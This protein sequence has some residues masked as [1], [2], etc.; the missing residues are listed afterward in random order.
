MSINA[1]NYSDNS[2]NSALNFTNSNTANSLQAS[3][4]QSTGANNIV[5]H[6]KGKKKGEPDDLEAQLQVLLSNLSQASSSTAP[7]ANINA[8]LKNPIVYQLLV[9]LG[10]VS[11]FSLATH[12]LLSVLPEVTQSKEAKLDSTKKLINDIINVNRE[13]SDKDIEQLIGSAMERLKPNYSIKNDP[14]KK[15]ILSFLLQLVY[16]PEQREKLISNYDKLQRF[17]DVAF[18]TLLKYIFLKDNDGTDEFKSLA[19]SSNANLWSSELSLLCKQLDAHSANKNKAIVECLTELAGQFELTTEERNIVFPKILSNL[20]GQLQKVLKKY[21]KPSDWNRDIKKSSII[22]QLSLIRLDELFNGGIYDINYELEGN[23][24]RREKIGKIVQDW[25]YKSYS[26]QRTTE[27]ALQDAKKQKDSRYEYVIENTLKPLKAFN[28]LTAREGVHSN[29]VLKIYPLDNKL[30]KEHLSVLEVL[31]SS[32]DSAGLVGVRDSEFF[33]KNYGVYGVGGNVKYETNA[34]GVGLYSTT[35]ALIDASEKLEKILYHGNNQFTNLMIDGKQIKTLESKGP[36]KYIFSLFRS[37]IKET[38]SYGDGSWEAGLSLPEQFAESLGY[39][40][41]DSIRDA[42]DYLATKAVEQVGKRASKKVLDEKIIELGKSDGFKQCLKDIKQRLLSRV[43]PFDI[44]KDVYEEKSQKLLFIKPPQ[45]NNSLIPIPKQDYEYLKNSSFDNLDN[46]LS[47][48]SNLYETA[49]ISVVVHAP[50]PDHDKHFNESSEYFFMADGLHETL[51][52]W[53]KAAENIPEIKNLLTQGGY[54]CL[55][56][57][58]EGF[59]DDLKVNVGKKGLFSMTYNGLLKYNLKKG[60]GPQNTVTYFELILGKLAKHL[61][62]HPEPLA[63]RQ[64]IMHGDSASDIVAVLKSLVYA[65]DSYGVQVRAITTMANI[66]ELTNKIFCVNTIKSGQEE[67]LAD[68]QNHLERICWKNERNEEFYENNISIQDIQKHLSTKF[69]FEIGSGGK[70][71]VLNKD[72]VNHINKTKR[73]DEKK[74]ILASEFLQGKVFDSEKEFNQYLNRISKNLKELREHFVNPY[75]SCPIL[76]EIQKD[77]KVKIVGAGILNGKVFDTE[78]AYKDFIFAKDSWFDKLFKNRLIRAD[79]VDHQIR[80]NALT[81]AITGGVPIETLEELIDNPSLLLDKTAPHRREYIYGPHASYV[82][83][84]EAF[85]KNLSTPKEDLYTLKNSIKEKLPIFTHRLVAGS[86]ISGMT[87]AAILAASFIYKQLTKDEYTP[88]HSPSIMGE[89]KS[90][91]R[92]RKHSKYRHTQNDLKLLLADLNNVLSTDPKKD[93]KDHKNKLNK[94]IATIQNISANMVTGGYIGMN[95]GSLLRNLFLSYPTQSTG[96]LGNLAALS[97]MFI[98]PQNI[99]LQRA[100]ILGSIALNMLSWANSLFFSEQLNVRL[101]LDP[102]KTLDGLQSEFEFKT[103]NAEHNQV[104]GK[105]YFAASKIQQI[106]KAGLDLEIKLL[107][108]VF[109][110]FFVKFLGGRPAGFVANFIA[111]LYKPSKAVWETAKN[112]KFFHDMVLYGPEVQEITRGQIIN[113]KM[114]S[115]KPLHEKIIN[116]ILKPFPMP[117]GV[118]FIISWGAFV[119]IAGL[120]LGSILEFFKNKKNDKDKDKNSTQSSQTQNDIMNHPAS[121]PL[122]VATT[123]SA[124]IPGLANATFAPIERIAG[125]G[126]PLTSYI[127]G[128]NSQ[129]FS[130]MSNFN[131]NLIGLGGLTSSLFSVLTLL[132]GNFGH[133]FS[134]FF[135]ISTMASSLGQMNS[136]IGYISPDGIQNQNVRMGGNAGRVSDHYMEIAKAK[137]RGTDKG[138]NHFPEVKGLS[139][140]SAQ[141]SSHGTVNSSPQRQR[142]SA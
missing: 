141:P 102:Q 17:K 117:H 87:G 122:M 29:Q 103:A 77:K 129:C 70:V 67:W 45:N 51:R 58:D 140:S 42:C 110:K 66:R 50:G 48:R 96:I 104:R 112:P 88:A 73:K 121:D 14:S 46:L 79:E 131:A 28:I 114:P 38:Q 49:P 53:N 136:S 123:L 120:M 142:V 3:L 39:L 54:D 81:S 47:F 98:A 135:D 1:L 74:L 78:E 105:P 100:T 71:K 63:D 138:F 65:P 60:Q 55:L 113:E 21:P 89:P 6:K 134:A 126:N 132:P 52:E 133:I 130:Q 139:L 128:T 106:N 69:A 33:R 41:G 7:V 72:E 93:S 82:D 22:N 99:A 23:N 92:H 20:Q 27:E 36:P 86:A 35:K 4:T 9:G 56:V 127:R 90:K 137:A 37:L 44:N 101:P 8:I 57:A 94:L 34:K 25:H 97:L 26:T 111:S 115:N 84:P 32:K 13:V 118:P 30:S 107:D 109:P 12:L 62:G 43:K 18:L 40:T 31:S 80:I 83:Q 119:P 15:K 10:S 91:F 75:Y 61:A 2:A 64:T 95:I 76:Y 108:K 11:T 116:R 5:P 24:G 68:H 85:N 125:T 19:I 124:T 59:P 16:T